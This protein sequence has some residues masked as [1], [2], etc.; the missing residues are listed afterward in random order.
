MI[1]RFFLALAVAAGL[2]SPA[3]AAGTIPFSLSQQFDQFGKPLA[4]CLLY[5]IKAGTTSTPQNGYQDSA[6]TTPLSNPI[7]CD[8]AGRLP[9]MFFADGSIKVRLTD[10]NG[11]NQVVADGIQVVGASSGSGGGGSVDATTIL[12]T[13]DLKVRYGT[14]SL[15]GFVRA[16]GRTIG[17]ATSGATER[18]NSDCQTLFEYLWNADSTLTVSGGR[19]SSANADWVANKT[20]ALPD[21][22]GRALAGLDDMGNSAASRLSASYFGTAATVL[23]AAGGSES[24][25][26]TVAQIPSHSH[27]IYLNDPGHNHAMNVNAYSTGVAGGSGPGVAPS[28]FQVTATSMASTGVTLW[29]GPSASGTQNA[30]AAAGG[31]SPHNIVQPTML[32]T[33]YIKL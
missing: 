19:G 9:Q 8:A 17:S 14:G 1:K 6:L 32:A 7:I 15:P 30:T 27:N 11:V 10:K 2:L 12:A 28:S 13:G 20:I 33:I 21:W 16:N 22:R 26:L 24:Q 18:A 4:G 31:G 25:T 23:G 3:H 29:S 5:T